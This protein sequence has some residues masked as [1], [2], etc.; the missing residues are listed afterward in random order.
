MY[1]GLRYMYTLALYSVVENCACAI[2]LAS[3]PAGN[4]G[5]EVAFKNIE[6]QESITVIAVVRCN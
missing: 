1:K 4:A 2:M 3:L 6:H 5:R